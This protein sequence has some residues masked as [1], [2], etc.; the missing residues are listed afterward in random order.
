MPVLLTLT[1]TAPDASALGFLL[2][3]HPGRAQVFDLSVGRAHVFYPEASA[4]R[5]TVALL[6]EVDPVEVVRG[7]RFSDHGTL[8]HYVNDRPYA[9]GS[10][11]AVALGKV[12]GTA[13]RG[14]CV[15]HEDLADAAL[16]LTVH[17][18][19]LP[20]RGG[21][22][23]VERLFGPVGWSVEAAPIPLDDAFPQWGDSR[24][25]D[26]TLTGVVRLADAL[27]HLYVLLPVLDGSKHYWVGPDEI[28][29]LLRRGGTWL[30]EHPERAWITR[31][32]LAH[33][34]E[35]VTDALTRLAALDDEAPEASDVAADPVECEATGN[36]D[37]GAE[38]IK[39]VPLVRRRKDAV[40]QALRDTGAH[41]V[42]DLGCGSGSL[43][44]ELLRDNTFTEVVGTDV[45]AG[46]LALAER[47]LRLDTMSD[48]NRARLTLLQTSAT[49]RDARLAA[50]DAIVLMEVIEHVDAERLPALVRAVF[51]HARPGCVVVTTPNVEYNVRYEGLGH[52]DLRHPDHRF[53][54]SRAQFQ[55]WAQSVAAEHG[56]TVEFRPVGDS[57]PEVGPPTQLGLFVRDQLVRGGVA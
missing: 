40:L 27:S 13:M 4:E 10:L 54:W 29:K 19:V 21:P 11:L 15:G 47:R 32:Y 53:E 20:C 38:A 1:S 46:A 25:V 36:D 45:S 31:R 44:H 48:R 18:P 2:H 30:A 35:F 7:R 52:S 34:R 14:T 28:D 5:C 24:Y 12:F 49:Y 37:I 9:A 16:P 55:S 50:Y 3:K 51:V 6:L 33:K 39:T 22:G 57:D 17:V 56:Y 43:L 8:A 26:V 42:V 23:Q 41:R